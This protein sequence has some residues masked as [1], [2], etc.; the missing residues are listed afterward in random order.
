[1]IIE[2]L[3][4]L[5]DDYC[6]KFMPI[7]ESQLIEDGARKRLRPTQLSRS[8]MITILIWYHQS[9]YCNFKSYYQYYLNEHLKSAFPNLVSYNRFIELIP[10]II[11]PLCGFL[12][13]CLGKST[14]INYIDSISLAVCSNKRIK[15]HR[16]FKGIAALGKT[17]KGWFYGFKLHLVCS[18]KGEILAV[19]ITPGNIDDRELSLA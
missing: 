1:M 8:E 9:H 16:V 11:L 5:V 2:E 19:K 3:Y 13:T 12:Q 15:N 14:G 7:W 17:T 4:C 10:W 18:H 6:K